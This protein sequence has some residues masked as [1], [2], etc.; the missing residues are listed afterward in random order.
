VNLPF[1]M[2]TI[3]LLL[4]LITLICGGFWALGAPKQQ[5]PPSRKHGRAG[6]GRARWFRCLGIGRRTLVMYI[7]IAVFYGQ[8]NRGDIALVRR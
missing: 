3:A 5:T 8:R 1:H 2:G 6:R 7:L 4:Q